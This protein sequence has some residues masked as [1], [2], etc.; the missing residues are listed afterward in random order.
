MKG[1]PM[2]K[3]IMIALVILALVQLAS[4][5][6]FSGTYS[7]AKAQAAKLGKPLLLEFYTDW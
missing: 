3:I 4:A 5:I 7:E 6:E 1:N 2:K